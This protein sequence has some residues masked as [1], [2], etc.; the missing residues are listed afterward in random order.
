VR[1]R[2]QPGDPV[3]RRT[4][5]VAGAPFRLAGVDRHADFQWRKPVRHL[6]GKSL[7]DDDRGRDSGLRGGKRGAECVTDRLEDGSAGGFDRRVEEGVVTSQRGRHGS[8]L[9]FPET[10]APFDVGEEEGDDL[11]LQVR[12]ERPSVSRAVPG[13]SRPGSGRGGAGR[14]TASIVHGF[15]AAEDE[16]ALGSSIRTPVAMG[17][18]VQAVMMVPTGSPLRARVRVP[19]FRPLMT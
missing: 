10:G 19:G 15:A 6:G 8:R 12:H 4:E 3:E 1:G 2:Q 16:F 14:T 9:S 5:I 13:S 11:G 17:R 18:G 7:L